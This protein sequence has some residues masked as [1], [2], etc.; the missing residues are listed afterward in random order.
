MAS[1]ISFTRVRVSALTSVYPFKALLTVEV[2][3]PSAWANCLM[4]TL[5]SANAVF[6]VGR[7]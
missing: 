3:S 4:L 1:A 7:V 6:V 2:D 5:V